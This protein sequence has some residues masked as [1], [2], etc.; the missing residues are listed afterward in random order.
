MTTQIRSGLELLYFVAGVVVAIGVIYGLKQI[1]L[2]KKDIRLRNERAAKEK[3]IEYG[4]NVR[5]FFDSPLAQSR[6][7]WYKRSTEDM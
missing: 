4:R 7:V 3:A 6:G 1:A 2:L 5:N